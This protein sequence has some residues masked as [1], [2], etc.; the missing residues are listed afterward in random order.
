MAHKAVSMKMSSMRFTR[1]PLAVG[2]VTMAILSGFACAFA[3]NPIGASPAAH[4]DG[5]HATSETAG[6]SQPG[7]WLLS[8]D[9]SVAGYGVPSLSS[10][11]GTGAASCGSGVAG[12][13]SP[14]T[15]IAATLDGGGYWISSGPSSPPYAGLVT[16]F[17]NAVLNVGASPLVISQRA[18]GV[19]ST[20]DGHGYWQSAADGGVFSFGDATFY[21]SA[22][23]SRLNQPIVGM[24]ATPDGAGYWLVAADGGVFSFGDATFYG[25]TASTRLNQPIVGMAAAPDGAGYWLVAADGGVF[26]FGDARF[27]GS[28]VSIRLNQPIVG[29]A[30]APDGAGYW[31][32]A[33]D[34]GVFSFGDAAFLGSMGGQRLGSRVVGIAAAG[35][36]QPNAYSVGGTVSGLSGTVV[37]Q[38]NGDD[39]LSINA[40]GAFT[41]PIPVAEGAAYNVTVLTQPATQTCTVTNGSGTMGAS[42]VTN[43]GV[44]CSTNA[45]SVGGTVS[46][47]SGTVVLQQNGDDNLSINANGAFTFPIPVAEGAAYNV[48]VL[49]Q[50]ATQTC[51]VTNGSGTMGASNVT[52]VDVT[53]STN[54]YSVG[55]TVSGLSGTVVLQQNGDDNLSINANGAFTFPIPVAEGAAYNVT[56]L[57][58]P[59]T[60]TCTVT[61]G[62]GTMGASNVTNVGVTC[63][64]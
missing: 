32:V 41:F 56:V 60:Q 61:N 42:N 39:N 46:G 40:N 53:C 11:T 31:L 35:N 12:S 16:G 15:G 34:G 59:A 55:G 4:A 20:A 43:V 47:L 6:R 1:L 14:C 13:P 44:T 58:Q 9:G 54:A 50:P 25:S 26:S 30:A 52:N 21:G 49:T 7:Y 10:A 3:S 48:T 36:N 57:T 17:G 63:S 8:S 22:A 37:L 19:A 29:M 27:Y 62:S 2:I 5:S 33:A 24:A 38:Q 18:V 45:Y 28:T 23:S 64:P 51:T